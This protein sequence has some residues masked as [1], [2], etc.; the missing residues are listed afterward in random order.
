MFFAEPANALANI[1]GALKPGGRLAASVWQPLDLNPWMTLTNAAAA[2]ALGIDRPPLPEPGAPGPF[3]MGDP[4]ATELLF[5]DAGF[6]D[7]RLESVEAPFVFP[8]DGVEAVERILSAG[9][10]G[11]ALLSADAPRRAE[12]VAAVVTALEEYRG[13]DG[14]EV[15]AASWCITARRP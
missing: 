10:L 11:S 12:A 1:F 4:D 3:S 2:Q 9:P 8:G 13:D 6:T 5:R 14:F 15:P 7:V